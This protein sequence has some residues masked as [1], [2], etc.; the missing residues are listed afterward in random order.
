M[1]DRIAHVEVEILGEKKVDDKG[2]AVVDLPEHPQAK[3]HADTFGDKFGLRCQNNSRHLA[4][5][6]VMTWARHKSR[7]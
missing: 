2:E 7:H 4:T 1:G 3:R 5:L 6:W